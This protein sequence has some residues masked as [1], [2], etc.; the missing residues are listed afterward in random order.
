MVL[1]GHFPAAIGK[2]QAISVYFPQSNL[3]TFIPVKIKGK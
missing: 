3:L 2:K 1:F